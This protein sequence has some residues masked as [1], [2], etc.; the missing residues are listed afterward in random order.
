MK[1]GELL[2]GVDEIKVP[3][4]LLGLE[5]TSLHHD[6]RAVKEGGIF[7]AF[8]GESVDGREFLKEAVKKGAKVIISDKDN[9]DFSSYNF[10]VPLF[11][12]ESAR[13]IESI[14]SSRFF[15]PSSNDLDL[16]IAI[17]GTN[18]KTSVSWLLAHAL[19]NI[20]SKS[21]MIGTLGMKTFNKDGEVLFERENST[22]TPDSILREEFLSKA[23]SKNVRSSLAMEVSSHALSQ[24][25]AYGINW[26]VAVFTNLT[27]DHLD[28]HITEESY[29]DAKKKLFFESL[30]LSKSRK[31][32]A[33]INIDDINGYKI[34]KTLEDNF[35]DIKVIKY[36]FREESDIL[37]KDISLY[38][39]GLSLILEIEKKELQ[40]KSFLVGEF[41]G[42][43]ISAI[44][45]I[46]FGLGINKNKFSD[47][48]SNIPPVPGRLERV[49][50]DRVNVFVDYAHTPDALEK[51]Q[52]SLRKITKGRLITV[53]GCGGDRD[54]G[55]RA[56][57]GKIVSLM[58]DFSIVTTDNPRTE[59]PVSIVEDIL[60]GMRDRDGR[61]LVPFEVIL[62]RK[63]AIKKAISMA[64]NEDI[65]LIAGKGHEDYQEIN[66][67]K[68]HF[69][70]VE[71]CKKC[72]SDVF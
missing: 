69:S 5:I 39:S 43:N 23:F 16:K 67:I 10:S 12:V 54:R 48:I 8:N 9:F 55:K 35:R 21:I 22:T 51:A 13:K 18:G 32:I 64:T 3:Y 41:N 50:S 60:G 31:K 63:D 58:A 20:Y 68:H 19:S 11:K 56:Q 2:F 27:R 25:R 65:V 44:I 52:S 62:S 46:L 17:T 66:G 70:D 53:F 71:E 57:M 34:A 30:V 42:E 28:Y 47:F 33:V 45:G 14:V 26:D 1:L 37:I 24:D 36:G 15:S 49:H 7:F 38:P 61:D 40:I 29:L 59:N 4:S 6:S 72:L